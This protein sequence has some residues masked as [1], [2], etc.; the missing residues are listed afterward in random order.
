MEEQTVPFGYI[1]DNC[2]YLN[3]WGNREERKVGEVKGDNE[4]DSIAHYV[5]RFEQYHEKVQALISKID[6][7]ENKGS[8]LVKL[9]HLKDELDKYEGL[10][11]YAPIAEKL[12]QYESLIKDI[13]E[14]NRKRNTDIKTAL[15]VE[16][17]QLEELINWKEATEF[18]N[19]LK[20]RWIKTGNAEEGINEELEQVFWE[21]IQT[22]FERKKQFFEDKKKL[23][24]LRKQDY[25]GLV[26][27]A[28][29]VKE[30]FGKEKYEKIDALKAK[31]KEIGGIPAETYQPLVQAFN[32]NLKARKPFPKTDYEAIN[33]ELSEVANGNK[34]FDRKAIESLKK[35]I[36]KDKTPSDAKASA[37][38]LIQ[39]LTERDF[40]IKIAKK[41][42]REFDSLDNE[43]KVKS[44][45]SV[46]KGLIKRDEE[47]LKIYEG[48][49]GMFSSR[50]GK[51]DNMISGK[52]NAQKKKIKMKTLLIEKLLSG[53]I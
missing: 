32:K 31:W 15:V 47:D 38:Q 8:F 33:K 16:T 5:K 39:L 35:N 13:I 4:Q 12:T 17:K 53:E 51:F 26:K 9:L 41:K 44:L 25:E 2:I 52:L 45:V 18:A 34:P 43:A 10:G 46:L 3:A 37:L 23:M 49:T 22:F 7:T 11:D 14:K 30:F 48:N 50:D 6:E 1:K 21:K 36:F 20:K 28:E 24:D 27:E 29:G 19:D 42:N 40:A